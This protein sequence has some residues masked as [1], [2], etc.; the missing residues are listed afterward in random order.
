MTATAASA[1]PTSHCTTRNRRTRLRASSREASIPAREGGPPIRPLAAIPAALI[2]LAVAAPAQ[3]QPYTGCE[4]PPCKRRAIA[5]YKP[6]LRAV[7]ACESGT[8]RW[9]RHGLHAV[10]PGGRYRGRYQFGLPDWRRAGG[11][12]DPADAGWLEQAYRAVVW[13]TVNGRRSWPNC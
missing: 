9:L 2:T 1:P 13:L 6:F 10:S 5:P 8:S 12:G 11:S 7:G 4:K 3:A